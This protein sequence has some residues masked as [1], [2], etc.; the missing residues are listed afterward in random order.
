MRQPFDANGS[1]NPGGWGDGSALA[2]KDVKSKDIAEPKYDYSV[3]DFSR[4]NVEVLPWYR[5]E[6]AYAPNGSGEG[7][8]PSN[9]AQKDVKAKDIAE[10]K[11]DYSVYDFSRDNVEVLPWYRT[12][13]AYAP[14]GSG[15]GRWPS[16]LAQ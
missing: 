9:L 1:R 5:T 10:P 14:N 13:T 16:T 8:W 15:E 11:Y 2:Q 4:D 12:E 3:Y 6:T 7:R